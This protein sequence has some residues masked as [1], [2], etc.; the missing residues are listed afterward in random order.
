MLHV[1]SDDDRVVV[2]STLKRLDTVQSE[3]LAQVFIH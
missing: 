2:Q 3:L 1:A